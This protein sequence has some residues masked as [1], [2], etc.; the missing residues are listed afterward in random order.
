MPV[1][2]NWSVDDFRKYGDLYGTKDDPSK[3]VSEVGKKN[4]PPAQSRGWFTSSHKSRVLKDTNVDNAHRVMNGYDISI[5][6][7]NNDLNSVQV[8]IADLIGE[9]HSNGYM[10]GDEVENFIR[11]HTRR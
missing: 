1:K 8:L 4:K 6:V 2:G 3:S 11:E 5:N 9:N 10:C 7:Y